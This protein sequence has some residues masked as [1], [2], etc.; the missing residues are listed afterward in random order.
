METTSTRPRRA[1]AAVTVGLLAL[2]STLAL[3]TPAQ[4]AQ[5]TDS[6]HGRSAGQICV[7][8][9]FSYTE[10]LKWWTVVW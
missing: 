2:A 9:D 6:E 3:S 4:A 10:C 8:W 7:E 1:L 5:R